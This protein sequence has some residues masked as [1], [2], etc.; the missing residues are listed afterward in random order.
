MHIYWIEGTDNGI[1]VTVVR[2]EDSC[3]AMTVKMEME[4][5]RAGCHQGSVSGIRIPL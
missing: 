3:G 4:R 2:E 1:M 5:W